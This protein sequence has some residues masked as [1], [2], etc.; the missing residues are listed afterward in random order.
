[1]LKKLGIAALSVLIFSGCGGGGSGGGG[2]GGGLPTQTA[3]FRIVN[4]CSYTIW[5]QHTNDPNS[6]NEIATLA[7]GGYVDY[8]I[9]N[10]GRASDRFW[11]KTGCDAGGQ[12]CA[13]GQSSNPCPAADAAGCAPPTD[14]K[15]EATWGCVISGGV[16]CAVTPQ[17]HA[18]PNVTSWDTSAVDGYSLPYKVTIVGGGGTVCTGADC[19]SCNA[20]DCTGLSLSNCPTDDNLSQGQT[21]VHAQYA[22]EDLR[23][24]NTASP[25][26][27]LG[28]YSPC[29][30]LNYPD[31]TGFNGENL[32]ETSDEAVMYCCPT[33]PIDT[34][35]CR[36]GPVVGT[37]YVAAV[38]SMCTGGVYAYAYDDVTGLH[39][40][41]GSTQFLMTFCP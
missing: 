5:V 29:K 31:N 20:V 6:I 39:N 15:F 1:M 34:A 23:V 8:T 4:N 18:I 25:G 21:A 38:H 16:G 2:G 22:S 19:S 13:T 17:G 24:M 40:C 41:A 12:N 11:P 28:C 27:V 7:T 9:P 37:K 36:A 35:A 10:Q 3:L 26:T 32:S 30:K 14:S 33:P